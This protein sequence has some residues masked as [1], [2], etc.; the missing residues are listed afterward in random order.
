MLRSVLV[1]LQ[2]RIVLILLTLAG[3]PRSFLD[4]YGLWCLATFPQML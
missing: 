3:N 2:A 4:I 1:L